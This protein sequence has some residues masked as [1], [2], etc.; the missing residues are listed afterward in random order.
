M[1]M[2]PIEDFEEEIVGDD[3]DY[4]AGNGNYKYRKKAQM[5]L[6]HN[7]QFQSSQCNNGEITE[8]LLNILKSV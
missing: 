5:S 3:D 6:G 4:E 8:F 7:C 1:I 2:Q